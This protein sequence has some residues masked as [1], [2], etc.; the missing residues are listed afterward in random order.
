MPLIAEKPSPETGGMGAWSKDQVLD[1]R[2]AWETW[3]PSTELAGNRISAA[4][5]E[6]DMMAFVVGCKGRR[7]M[8]SPEWFDS[9][10]RVAGREELVELDPTS[11]EGWLLCCLLLYRLDGGTLE[12]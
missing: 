4:A 1:S 2:L 5:V 12:D 11:T 9:W 7:V 3:S 6:E 10:R 8:A